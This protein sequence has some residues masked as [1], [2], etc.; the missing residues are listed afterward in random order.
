MIYR[1]KF[2]SG[3]GG[4]D[5]DY[6]NRDGDDD[7]G[8]GYPENEQAMVI[9]MMTTTVAMTMT[10]TTTVKKTMRMILMMMTTKVAIIV[11]T[12]RRVIMDYEDD[13]G[14]FYLCFKEGIDMSTQWSFLTHGPLGHEKPG[15]APG[16]PYS[17]RIVRGFFNVSQNYQHSRNCET[18]P[19]VYCP[20]PRRLESLTICR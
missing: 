9:M 13:I 10:R 12:T 18:G 19:P 6:E 5:V 14:L 2:R 4:D 8:T 11:T 7:G 1:C 15:T 20:Y 3:V 17:Y 16:S